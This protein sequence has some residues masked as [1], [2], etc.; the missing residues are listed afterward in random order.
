MMCKRTVEWQS[1][2]KWQKANFFEVVQQYGYPRNFLRILSRMKE[3]KSENITK[4]G[5]TISI[6]RKGIYS[7][8]KDV[9]TPRNQTEK[10]FAARNH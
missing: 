2:E 7:N 4:H 9:Q 8:C 6:H 10:R 5:I 1:R 3:D